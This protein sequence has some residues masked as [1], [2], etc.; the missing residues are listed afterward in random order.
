MVAETVAGCCG[1]L[2]VRV[3][4][5]DTVHIVEGGSR[6]FK[7]YVL[8]TRPQFLTLALVLVVHGSA[9][10]A[11]H[12]SIH[13]G[14]SILAAIGLILL[15]ASVNVLNDWHDWTRSGI[16][17]D[18]VQTPFSGGSGMLPARDLEPR[19]AL[20]LG[21][22]TLL[23][24]SAIGLYLAWAAGWELLI[25]GLVGAVLVVLYTPVFTRTGLGEIMAGAG[26]GI[27]PVVGTY[28]LITGGFDTAAWVSGIPA[29]LL[30]YNLLLLNEF[31][32]TTA[33][34]AGGRHHMVVLLGKRRARWLYAV[35]EAAAFVVIVIGVVTGILTP[36]VLLA[37][38]AAVPA[39]KAVT[40]AIREYDGFEELIPALG[41]NV[42]ALLGVNVLMAAGY[43][44]AALLG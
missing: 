39:A 5:P 42:Q 37:L 17:H 16:D 11:W 15:Q 35:A 25:I 38:V 24:G 8:E 36:W 6:V 40:I 1:T 34:T 30:T 44:I 28:F 18:T 26:L 7:K 32:D 13:I 10:A 20:I 14:R 23:A 2:R 3:Y 12:G 33:D 29:T 41:A 22:G 9:L 27:L 21:I 43:A 4:C 31:P 19:E